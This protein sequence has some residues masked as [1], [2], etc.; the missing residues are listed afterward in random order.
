MPET[1]SLR[2]VG[3]EE[4]LLLLDGETGVPRAVAGNL[5]H[6]ADDSAPVEGDIEAELQQQQ[7]EVETSPSLAMDDLEQ[8]LRNWRR[9]ADDLARHNGAR[10]VASGT[11]PLPVDPRT[12][13][14]PRYQRM[15]ERFGLT[16]VEQLA[17][18]CHVH[19]GVDSDELRVAVI[20]RIQR[21]LPC[22][23]ALSANSPFWQGQDS[24]YA[25]YRTQVWSRFPTTGPTP[26][27]GD[28]QS[29]HDHVSRLIG[30]GVPVD[31][32]MVYFNARLSRHYP[33]VEIRVADVCL[34]VEDAITIAA[35]IRALVDTAADEAA[36]GAPA[37]ALHPDLLRLAQWQASRYGLTGDLLDP[38]VATPRPADTVIGELL[39]HVAPALK[40]N[41]DHE[42]VRDGIDRIIRQGTG[43][44]IQRQAIRDGAEPAELVQ[45]MIDLTVA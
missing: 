31:A 2:T 40:N 17:C 22:L 4:E 6:R 16:T 23:L 32:D 3:V 14:K 33:T 34:R 7:I 8:Q 42:R 5:L 1:T 21:W 10:I 26:L 44:E 37:P 28:P 36:A 39:E 9:Y 38:D 20:D 19:V 41:G 18:G 24:G 27:F 35:L 13:I 15:V 29:Y 11:S 12:M 43:S 45:T 25:S 30:T